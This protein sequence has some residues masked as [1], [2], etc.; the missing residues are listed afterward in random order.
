MTEQELVK[1]CLNDIC[2]KNG[3][4]GCA[5][6]TQRDF[7][8]L[9]R[10]IE[11]NT[12]ILISVST[13]KRLLNGDFNRL[14]QTA[15]LNA[16]STYLGFKNWQAYKTSLNG[17]GSLSNINKVTEVREKL[18]PKLQQ[19]WKWIAG[20][21][22]VLTIFFFIRFNKLFSNSIKNYEKA[23]F[24]A[25][26]T[27]KSAIPN[28]VIFSY[29]IDDIEA[30]SF[31]IQQSWDK[32]RRVR[33]YKNNYILTDIYYE[34]G[35]HTAKLMANDSI[36][37]TV[38]VSIPTDSWFLYICDI[39]HKNDPQYIKN[40]TAFKNGFLG[41]NKSDLEQNQ[42]KNDEE[43]AFFYTYFPSSITENSDNYHFKARA[44]MKEVRNNH[45]PYIMYEIFTQKHFNFIKSYNDGCASE[46]QAGF[47]ENFMK[48]RNVDLSP[49][50]SN[51]FQWTDLEIIVKNKHVEIFV[52]E[53]K[54]FSA[55]Y[56]DSSGLITGLGFISNGLCDVDFVELKT[57]E[58]KVIYQ[59]NF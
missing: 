33:I 36:I 16:I 6:M 17:N 29:N 27:T 3:F 1:K 26:K 50:C 55:N 14:P 57:L 59:N 44:K 53:K 40:N 25:N 11:E 7:E 58:G 34:P 45:C 37:R 54:V 43:R 51:V 47:G 13:I 23:Q 10:T 19:T 9:S 22:I 15:T 2:K 38:F 39:A 41:L 8:L 20:L 5:N 42:I 48:G 18:A 4:D 52:N 46:A 56:H 24:E 49:I 35:Y 31:F 12:G 21:V 30:D 32:N 28:T